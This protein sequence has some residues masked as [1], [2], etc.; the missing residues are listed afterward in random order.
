[1]GFVELNGLPPF[2]ETWRGDPAATRRCRALMTDSRYAWLRV[3][4]DGPG[5]AQ[6]RAVSTDG[7]GVVTW[8]RP[9]TD[10]ADA[11]AFGRPGSRR[12]TQRWQLGDDLQRIVRV[13]GRLDRP[14]LAEITEVSPP[15]A[16]G[17]VTE[18]R[19]EGNRLVIGAP[20]L[21]AVATVDVSEG[22]WAITDGVAELRVGPGARS[23]DVSVTLAPGDHAP[24]DAAAATDAPAASAQDGPR[25]A[26]IE[27]LA[28]RALAYVRGCTALAYGPDERAILTD[29][30]VLPLSWTR[31]AYYQALLLVAGGEPADLDVVSD[32][33]RWLWRRCERAD[34]RW[35]RSHHGNGAPKDLAFQADQQLYPFVELA[36]LWR[37]SGSLP[38]GVDWPRVLPDAW[39]SVLAAIDPV[40]GL[41]GTDENAADDRVDAPYV[42]ASQVTLW[43]TAMRLAEPALAPRIG[44]EPDDL[45]T[46]AAR[47]RAA[48]DRHIVIGGRWAYATDGRNRTID[49]HDANDLPTALAPAWGFCSP[50]DPGWRATMEF[51]FS[52]ANPGFVGGQD[53]GLGSGHTPG[54]WPLGHVQAWLA[55]VALGDAP[56]AAAALDRLQRAAFADG[57]LPEAWVCDGAELIP[58][59]HWFGWPGAALG[60]FWLLD[61]RGTWDSLAARRV[62][63]S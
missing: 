46:T 28:S 52:P 23:F 41:I 10:Q 39:R 24:A 22:R 29:H 57:M 51:A 44:L 18:L 26:G 16:T 14:A 25:L 62:G 56:A 30:R 40:T 35:M 11:V 15:A 33:L 59:R 61:R 42:A 5:E 36:D 38:D 20:A 48:F 4:S 58:I 63:V 7:P 60:A 37:A 49:C 54:A 19:A 31:D 45:L 55:G 21:P 47:V 17:A 32:H 2:D 3:V 50:D 8:S 9:G 34:G 1:V 6:T 13:S 27:R 12:V 53:G 43:Y